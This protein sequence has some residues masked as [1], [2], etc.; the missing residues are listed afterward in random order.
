MSSEWY[1]LMST[2]TATTI[3]PTAILGDPA[4]LRGVLKRI[5]GSKSDYWNAEL[6]N[7]VIR[8]LWIKNSDEAAAAS[9]VSAAAAALVGIAPKDEL[10]GMMAAQLIAAHNAT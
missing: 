10:E 7:Q 4:L 1:G 6:I 9:Q 2:K 3:G 8:A 5:G